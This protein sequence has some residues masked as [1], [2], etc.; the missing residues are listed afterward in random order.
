MPTPESESLLGSV[1]L[2]NVAS[3][4]RSGGCLLCWELVGGKKVASMKGAET[5]EAEICVRGV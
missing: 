3:G 2:T 5:E 1:F 4:D